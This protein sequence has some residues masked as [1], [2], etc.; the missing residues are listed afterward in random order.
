MSVYLLKPIVDG[1]EEHNARGENQELPLIARYDHPFATSCHKLVLSRSAESL[2]FDAVAYN[3]RAIVP[4]TGMFIL[5]S[6][7]PMP[8]FG[9]ILPANQNAPFVSRIL[10]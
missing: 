10:A 5:R 4:F 8:Q 1:E 7:H 2:L 6:Y 9:N 3:A